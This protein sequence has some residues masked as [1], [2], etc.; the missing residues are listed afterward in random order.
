MDWISVFAAVVLFF[1]VVGLFVQA[2]MASKDQTRAL[3]AGEPV[4]SLWHHMMALHR[5][6]A[7]EKALREE[8]KFRA[9][10]NQM[11]G[12]Q[13]AVTPASTRSAPSRAI[14]NGWSMGEVAFTYEDG[15]GDITFRYVTVHSV[16]ATHLKGECHDRQAERTF[17]IDRILGDITDCETGEILS[18][19]KYVASMR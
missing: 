6:R 2:V 9:D 16:T 5:K 13:A 1:S 11:R 18:A 12:P 19:R 15:D 4:G 8:L 7:A 10:V 17:R 3:M 14:R